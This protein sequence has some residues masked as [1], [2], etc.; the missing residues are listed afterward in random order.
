MKSGILDRSRHGCHSHSHR[1]PFGRSLAARI[2]HRPFTTGCL[3]IAIALLLI[4][5]IRTYPTGLFPGNYFATVDMLIRREL[6]AKRVAL[7]KAQFELVQRTKN[8]NA[9]STNVGVVIPKIRSD[10]V[11]WLWKYLKKQY[12][13]AMACS[14]TPLTTV[15]FLAMTPQPLFIPLTKD[16]NWIYIS[17]TLVAAA[18]CPLTSPT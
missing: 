3:I 2:R 11:Q 12:A 4:T 13:T 9:Y 18:R 15:P 17:R 8:Y 1:R 7:R 10:D 6:S 14:A 16:R 5:G